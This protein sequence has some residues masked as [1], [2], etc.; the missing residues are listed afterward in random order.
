MD[1]KQ[2]LELEDKAYELRKH[3]LT[4]CNQTLMHIGGD[5]SVVEVMT[6]LWQ[7]A[8]KYDANNPQWEQ[9]DR[10]VLSK[11]HA[12]A[13]TSFSQ[14]IRGCYDA[15][16]IY[17]EYASDNGR[18]GMHSCNLINPYVDVSTGSLGHGLPVAVGRAKA[19]RDKASDS[20]VYVVIGDGELNEGSMWEGIMTAAHYKLGNVVAFLD[21]NKLQFDGF[22]KDVMGMDPMTDKWKAFGWN[23]IEVDGHDIKALVDVVDH[24]PSPQSDAPTLVLCN[25]VKGNGISYMANSKKWHAGQLSDADYQQAMK[26]IEQNYKE[27]RGEA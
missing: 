17:K 4:L 10:F 11:G 25:T 14:A 9:R 15:E 23:V 12:A 5:F 18:F 6:V 8:I 26:D 20:R 24:L 22:T 2:L 1:E 27:K 13:V 3:L 7:Y 21:Y 16:D 19:L